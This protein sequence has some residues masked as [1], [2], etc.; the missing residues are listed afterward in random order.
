MTLMQFVTVACNGTLHF[1]IAVLEL[2]KQ[3]CGFSPP[4][5]SPPLGDEVDEVG[6]ELTPSGWV[7][8]LLMEVGILDLPLFV[9]FIRQ[10]RYLLATR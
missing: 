9:Y 2:L 7:T 5:P 4:F 8:V 3:K 10:C 1:M 6:V